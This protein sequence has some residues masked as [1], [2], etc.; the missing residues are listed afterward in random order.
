MLDSWNI[1]LMSYHVKLLVVRLMCLIMYWLH[2][3]F[4]LQD[5]SR[6]KMIPKII[7]IIFVNLRM[8]SPA[9]ILISYMEKL[10]YLYNKL[11]YQTQADLGAETVLEQVSNNFQQQL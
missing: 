5:R 2:T 6:E 9:N 7:F 1:D 4:I 11:V 10:D 3:T 8:Y